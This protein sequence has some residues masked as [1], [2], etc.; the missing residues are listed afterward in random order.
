MGWSSRPVRELFVEQSDEFNS[1]RDQTWIGD[2]HGP[3]LDIRK[4]LGFPLPLGLPILAVGH[5]DD[6]ALTAELH[7]GHAYGGLQHAPGGVQGAARICEDKRTDLRTV[8]R[9][10]LGLDEALGAFRLAAP[11]GD[12]DRDEGIVLLQ[13]GGTR[14]AKQ[15]FLSVFCDRGGVTGAVVIA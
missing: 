6:L 1:V 9:T 5:A 8:E 2:E 4:A 12:P 13:F 14:A 10:D 3:T 7:E 11:P 15:H